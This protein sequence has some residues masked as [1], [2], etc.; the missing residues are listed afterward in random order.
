MLT[1][2]AGPRN[3]AGQ[4]FAKANLKV[5]MAVMLRGYEWDIREEAQDLS[6]RF[7]PN[8]CWG[9]GVLSSV[10]RRVR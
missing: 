9:D 1:F 10:T 4:L 8:L 2:G 7:T 3:C 6:P 5:L